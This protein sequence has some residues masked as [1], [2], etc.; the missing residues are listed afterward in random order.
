MQTYTHTERRKKNTAKAEHLLAIANVQ[1][2][3]T[4]RSFFYQRNRIQVDGTG[5]FVYEY[6]QLRVCFLFEILR[7]VWNMSISVVR[8]GVHMVNFSSLLN[9]WIDKFIHIQSMTDSLWKS[10]IEW[11]ELH[12]N[13]SVDR[14]LSSF[15]R[16]L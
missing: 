2:E 3:P 11:D 14:S 4:E 9:E 8:F 16:P 6:L 13:C 5:K 15:E 7:Y 10:K 1:F 12:S